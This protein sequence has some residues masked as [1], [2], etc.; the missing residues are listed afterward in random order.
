MKTAEYIKDVSGFTGEAKLYKITKEIET[1]KLN[2]SYVV[3]SATFVLD[4]CETYIF[5]SDKNG[6]VTNWFELEG[7]CNDVYDH[8]EALIN[9]GYDIV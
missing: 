2:V 9:G 5:E 1:N 3:V 4:R 6:N 7:S 8:E